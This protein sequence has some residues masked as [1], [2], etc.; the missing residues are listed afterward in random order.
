MN[1]TSDYYR[2]LCFYHLRKKLEKQ[3]HFKEQSI[4]EEEED[5]EEAFW[6]RS[7]QPFCERSE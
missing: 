7:E 6:E 1:H 5:A 4:S 3:S 2:L